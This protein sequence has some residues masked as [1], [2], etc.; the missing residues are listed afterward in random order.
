MKDNHANIKPNLI[1][2]NNEIEAN[3]SAYIGTFKEDEMF[4]LMS[5]G[6]NKKNCY[7][8]LLKAFLLNNMQIESEK[9]VNIIDTLGGE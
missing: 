1:I 6:I 3:H 9:F 4:Y 2:D 5:R 8:L 7:K